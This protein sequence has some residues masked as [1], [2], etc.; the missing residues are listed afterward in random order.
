MKR[1]DTDVKNVWR[2][3]LFSNILYGGYHDRRNCIPEQRYFVQN[4]QPD[5]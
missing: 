3:K 1:V 2:V 5:L 4:S